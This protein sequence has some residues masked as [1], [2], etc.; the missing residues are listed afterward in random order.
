MT[1]CWTQNLEIG[2]FESECQFM[3]C[4]FLCYLGLIP[5]PLWARFSRHRTG[6]AKG[7]WVVFFLMFFM[8]LEGQTGTEKW[9]ASSF[10]S[11]ICFVW[12]RCKHQNW[13]PWRCFLGQSLD[14]GEFSCSFTLSGSPALVVYHCVLVCIGITW[15]ACE[16]RC[17]TLSHSFWCIDLEWGWWA[18]QETILFGPVFCLSLKSCATWT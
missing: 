2:T 13:M 9:A 16:N 4:L 1:Q 8:L 11:K 7:L 5:Q 17:R 18:G 6:G 14:K 10:G 12:V 15:R 3:F